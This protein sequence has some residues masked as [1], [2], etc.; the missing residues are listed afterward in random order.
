M[1]LGF[2]IGYLTGCVVCFIIE[3]ICWRSDNK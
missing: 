3:L 1:W 2:I